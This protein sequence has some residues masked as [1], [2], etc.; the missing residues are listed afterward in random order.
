MKDSDPD[1][2]HRER[3]QGGA[4]EAAIAARAIMYSLRRL[5]ACRTLIQ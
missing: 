2:P 1:N 4:R 5:Y 3:S